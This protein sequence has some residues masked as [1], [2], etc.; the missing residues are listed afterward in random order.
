MKSFQQFVAE[1]TYDPEIQGRSQIKQTGEGGRKEPKRDTASRRRP[2]VKPRVKAVGGG[3][4]APV[5]EYKTRKDVGST[6]ARS[7]R[8]QQPT[9]ERGSAEVKQTY[10]DKVKAERRAAAKARA[11]AKKSG[12]EVKKTTT[13]SKDAEKQA[14]KL[15]KKKETKKVNPNYK[16]REASGY[17][18]QERMKITRAGERELKGIMKKQETDKYKKETGQNPDAK[19]RTKI[20]GRVHK[21]MSEDTVLEAQAITN[22]TQGGSSGTRDDMEVKKK[23]P[24]LL[25][26]LQGKRDA[27]KATNNV[28][29]AAGQSV[30]N[31]TDNTAGTGSQRKP[32]PY[33]QANKTATPKREKGGEI[34]KVGDN[35]TSAV[36]KKP[37]SQEV[38]KARVKVM[39][40]VQG[41]PMLGS[42]QRPDLAGAKPQPQIAGVPAQKQL[43]AGQQ[44]KLSA[45]PERK[46]L[47]A[48]R[49]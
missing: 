3:K 21:R 47:P 6:K 14:S 43:P 45:N 12:G 35:K 5:G 40:K 1:A 19:G 22:T 30:K 32:Q 10:A 31:A 23:Q 39:Q 42:A 33:R 46:A 29:K 48:A 11:A 8:E 41:R 17:T 2:G 15:L 9:K 26:K 28:A 49:S 36:V 16:P 44:Q 37:A 27:K 24:S 7:E 25:K 4:T 20:L 13:S 38:Q 18:R 34:T